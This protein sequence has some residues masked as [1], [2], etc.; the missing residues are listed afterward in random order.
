MEVAARCLHTYRRNIA[1]VS[2]T[3]ACIARIL[4]AASTIASCSTC[5][6]QVAL[7]T[8]L[9][10]HRERGSTKTNAEGR[11]YADKQVTPRHEAYIVRI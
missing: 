4:V 2:W 11:G 3:R 1:T 5:V 9:I 8:A 10:R 7:G 6:P